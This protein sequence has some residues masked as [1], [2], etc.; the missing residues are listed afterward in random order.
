MTQTVLSLNSYH[1]RR[2]GADVAY[3]AHSD[4]M[5]RA[6][7]RARSFAMQ[8]PQNLP[9]AEA[10]YFADPTDAEL[11]TT[12]R[13]RLR[14]AGRTIWNRNAAR[15]LDQL[16][17]C[18]GRPDI[19]HVHSIYHHLTPS[20]LGPLTRRGVP[21]VMTAHDL[22]LACPAYRMV[23][24]DKPCEACQG[25]RYLNTLTRRC[26]KGAALPSAIVAVEAT[27]HRY[28]RS[29]DPVRRIIC[30]S[31]FYLE[32]LV[33][34]GLPRARLIHIPN[35]VD[36]IDPKFVGSYDEPILYV[37]RLSS[38]KG[39][40][41]LVKAAALSRVPVTILGRG[42][43]EGALIQQI[44]D[45]QAPVQ[46]LGWQEGGSLWQRVGRA[47]ALVLPS[48]WYENAP[49]SVLEGFSLARPALVS[50]M[51]GLPELVRPANGQDAPGWTFASGN[52]EGLAQALQ[53][54]QALSGAELARHGAAAQHLAATRYGP[55]RYLAA[56]TGLYGQVA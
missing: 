27:V 1:Y 55:A 33:Q 5:R 6:G 54:V 44:A 35:F 51:G 32:K 41:T 13:D 45:D 9:S 3:L 23:H 49:L 11:A 38:E 39:L 8:H 22:K 14:L 53:Q 29:Y 56:I 17:D 50:D 46:L 37:G 25:G 31:G 21:V 47:R 19:A 30:P 28:L 42:P 40:R 24:Q 43:D 10:P 16:L 34:W 36:P 18:V 7:W 48:E 52:V 20:V 2:G 26:I 4:L 12:A 15:R